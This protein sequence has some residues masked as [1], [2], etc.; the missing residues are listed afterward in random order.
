MT[1]PA[2]V[3]YKGHTRKKA[4]TFAQAGPELT[5]SGID[6]AKRGAALKIKLNV[7][8]THCAAGR[9]DFAATTTVGGGCPVTARAATH[10][11]RPKGWAPCEGC[12]IPTNYPGV[13]ACPA[14]IRVC[15]SGNAFGGVTYAGCLRACQ[16]LSPAALY[17]LYEPLDTNT[18]VCYCFESATGVGENTSGYDFYAV[19]QPRSPPQ[20][21]CP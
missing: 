15:G 9:L 4:A 20:T 17:M 2:G 10:V 6:L 12:S 5:W 3:L 1:L 13:Y 7:N 14:L 16:D 8:V 19:G 21:P 11:K 18:G